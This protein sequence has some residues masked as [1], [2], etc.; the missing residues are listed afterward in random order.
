MR[1]LA[2]AVVVVF[3][4][5]GTSSA[6]AF[7]FVI[8]GAKRCIT[9]ENPTVTE[10]PTAWSTFVP[11]APAV[12]PQPYYAVGYGV[13]PGENP[14][15]ERGFYVP[16]AG[17]LRITGGSHTLASW[18]PLTR[19]EAAAY[20]GATR[21]LAPYPAPTTL[22]SVIVDH[23]R[24]TDPTSY[25]RLYTFNTHAPK[26]T[27]ASDWIAI[28]FIG[29]ATPWTDGLVTIAVSRHANLLKREGRIFTIPATIAA[30]A[31]A[32]RSLGK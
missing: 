15:G 22:R 25:L 30:R 11:I 32:G 8:C 13:P 18:V 26:G 3:A 4:L 17:L 23:A 29:D 1:R 31:R 2:L 21:G 6:W 9:T 27:R 20:K 24:A 16:G 19:Q 10:V 14:A 28:S 7:P 5:T 12:P